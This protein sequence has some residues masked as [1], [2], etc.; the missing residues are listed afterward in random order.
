M[1]RTNILLA[2]ASHTMAEEVFE[3]RQVVQQA[4]EIGF[5]SLL[6]SFQAEKAVSVEADA[7]DL[8]VVLCLLHVVQQTVFYVVSIMV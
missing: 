3:D 8:F 4:V 1:D 2:E 5:Y 7:V 6:P